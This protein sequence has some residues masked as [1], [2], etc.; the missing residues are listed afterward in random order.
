LTM[1]TKS[2]ILHNMDSVTD[3]QN[4]DD[5]RIIPPEKQTLVVVDAYNLSQSRLFITARL[6]YRPKW[7]FFCVPAI[8]DVNFGDRLLLVI[9]HNTIPPTSKLYLQRGDFL[10]YRLQVYEC[11]K[12]LLE[13]AIE[14][15]PII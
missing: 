5:L 15:L 13:K 8:S 11:P 14:E 12:V 9:D 10:V 2:F 4:V 6:R 7:F 1:R 3:D